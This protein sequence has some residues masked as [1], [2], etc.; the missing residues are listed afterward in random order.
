MYRCFV[1]IETVEDGTKK[2]FL[3]VPQPR[4]RSGETLSPLGADLS[5]ATDDRRPFENV[6]VARAEDEDDID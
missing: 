6:Y 1:A 4:I 3:H 5:G 2:Y